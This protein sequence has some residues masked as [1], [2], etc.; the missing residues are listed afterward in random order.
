VT[1]CLSGPEAER[2]FRG[3]MV[4]GGDAPDQRMARQHASER[5]ASFEVEAE[6]SR[7]CAAA[8]R[9]V[10]SVGGGEWAITLIARALLSHG[11]L[12]GKEI[13]ASSVE[14]SRAFK[15]TARAGGGQLGVV[16]RAAPPAVR[17]PQRSAT[18]SAPPLSGAHV[19][20][21]RRRLFPVGQR[22]ARPS[23]RQPAGPASASAHMRT[24]SRLA[25]RAFFGN[26]NLE[27]PPVR[28]AWTTSDKKGKGFRRGPES[29]FGKDVQQLALGDDRRRGL[30][31]ADVRP[32]AGYAQ[33]SEC[34]GHC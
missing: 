28:P 23:E 29:L 7:C 32:A 5:L 31:L 15:I 11:T 4:A 34:C 12:N 18:D 17:L 19:R 20:L 1:L 25:T 21:T 33:E 30:A 9:M 13:G 6:L 10:R 16:D 27:A 2:V 3:P 22:G 8:A 24:R 26:T 14:H